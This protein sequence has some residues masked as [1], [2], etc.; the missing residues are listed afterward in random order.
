MKKL[1]FLEPKIKIRLGIAT[2]GSMFEGLVLRGGV[3]VLS[4]KP[5][6]L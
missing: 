6:S 3:V 2:G 5:V 4:M 1:I